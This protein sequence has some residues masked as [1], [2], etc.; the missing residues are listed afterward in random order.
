[1]NSKKKN[2]EI[3]GWLM[4]PMTVGAAAVIA[5]PGG[6]RRTSTVLQMEQISSVEIRFE[7]RN[8]N[9]CLHLIRQEVTA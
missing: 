8:T 7:T 2:M 4:C 3:T 6:M 9:Y 5:E 1:M